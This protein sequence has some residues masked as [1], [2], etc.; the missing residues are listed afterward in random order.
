MRQKRCPHR[1]S[2]PSVPLRSVPRHRRVQRR[3]GGVTLLLAA[4]AVTGSSCAL[5]GHSGAPPAPRVLGEPRGTPLMVGQPAPA[6]TGELERGVL[7]QCPALLGGRR[8]R[9]QSGPG[10]GGDNRDRRHDQ[11]RRVVEGPA[12]GGREHATAQRGLLPHGDQ[13]HGGRVERG[14]TTREWSRG[15]DHQRRLDV[16]AGNVADQRPCPDQCRVHR[17]V[18]LHCHRD[19]RH[20]EVVGPQRQFRTELAT[21]GRPPLPL[22]PGQRSHVRWQR[23]V[24]RR[25]VHSNQYRPRGRAR[26]H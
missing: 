14:I 9:T 23:L 22:P 19:R 15:D 7:R 3:S 18:Q 21:R 4:V 1:Y 2:R 16:G 6:G 13:V 12:R 25:R 11:W 26:S 24:P 10:G 8:R 20:A 17:F 5:T